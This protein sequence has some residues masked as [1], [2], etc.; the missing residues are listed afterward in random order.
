[1]S[2]GLSTP[3]ELIHPAADI[4]VARRSALRIV[5]P[6]EHDSRP[7]ARAPIARRATLT[8]SKAAAECAGWIQ[9]FCMRVAVDAVPR[10]QI[11]DEVGAAGG[12]IDQP[13]AALGA[14]LR[15]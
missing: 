10:D 14:E 6:V 5:L 13:F 3:P 15:R 7:A 4:A 8:F 1:M 2:T 9:P 11:E 12:K